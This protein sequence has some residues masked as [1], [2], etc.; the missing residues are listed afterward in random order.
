MLASVWVDLGANGWPQDCQLEVTW[1]WSHVHFWN[2]GGW[3]R[4]LYSVNLEEDMESGI[5]IMRQVLIPALGAAV[6]QVWRNQQ[7]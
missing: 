4:E 6:N 2:D 1:L 5:H 3:A 7:T